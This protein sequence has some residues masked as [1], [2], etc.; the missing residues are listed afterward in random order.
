MDGI[1]GADALVAETA[2]EAAAATD[3][4]FDLQPRLV[5][6]QHV[7]DDREAE[8]GTAAFAR[9]AGGSAAGMP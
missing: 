4:A 3:F 9:T 2:G 5:Q 8:A 1:A 6:V 7:L